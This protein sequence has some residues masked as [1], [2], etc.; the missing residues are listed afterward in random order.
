MK[1]MLTIGSAANGRAVVV[2]H[3]IEHPLAHGAKGPQ[4][5]VVSQDPFPVYE[6]MGV[7]EADRTDRGAP[8]MRHDR[9]RK[10]PGR[11]AAEVLAVIRR[12]CLPLDLRHTISIR[13]HAP[14]VRVT[15]AGLILTTLDHEGIL[16]MDEG[17]FDF[18]WL[19]RPESV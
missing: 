16:R 17:A 10:D 3:G 13:G 15:D 4:G 9:A 12:P 7:F 2:R 5:A 11:G 6:G 14:A 1:H 8:H 19:S 18:G